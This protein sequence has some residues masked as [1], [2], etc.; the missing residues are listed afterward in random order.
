M[1]TRRIRSWTFPAAIAGGVLVAAGSV[2]VLIG[3]S[4]PPP[5]RDASGNPLQIVLFQPPEPEI[6][7]GSVMDVGPVVD[8]YEHSTP[9]P[10]P[11]APYLDAAWLYE[12]TPD[13]PEPFARPVR[14]GEFAR[15]VVYTAVQ[16][17]PASDEPMTIR[18]D[19]PMPS[20][21][22]ARRQR[23]A[24]L[25]RRMTERQAAA[26]PTSRNENGQLR[27]D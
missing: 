15:V 9:A 17:Q 6:R 1:A 19:D 27:A 22:E 11:A 24:E 12:D 8:G 2:A 23:E 18:F 4:A 26:F 16:P 3:G 14:D 13:E 7:P 20:Y 25:D 21:A 10:P 5:G